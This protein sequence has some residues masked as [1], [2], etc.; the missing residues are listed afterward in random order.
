MPI[1][2]SIVNEDKSI[3]FADDNE[4][5]IGLCFSGG[6]LRAIAFQLG[7]LRAL[8]KYAL[9][10]SVKVISAVSGGAI[11]AAMYAYSEGSFEAFEKDVVLLLRQG[12]AG[13]LLRRI[14]FSFR[15]VLSFMTWLIS[16]TSAFL[17]DSI[18]ALLTFVTLHLRT[19]DYNHTPGFLF[20]IR[21]PFRRWS[22][23]TSVLED[24]LKDKIFKDKKLGSARRNNVE[25]VLN[26]TDLINTG[27][28][29][30]TSRRSGCK[31]FGDIEDN[32]VTVAHAVAASS[33]HPVFFPAIDAVYTFIDK[34]G[35]SARKNVLLSD[36]GIIDN[37][38]TTC[39]R[40]DR[41]PGDDYI[42]FKTDYIVISTAIQG[43][44]DSIPY[45]LIPR[46][47]RVSETINRRLLEF[48]HDNLKKSLDSRQIEGFVFL[49]LSNG[50]H[51]KIQNYP[52]N[53]FAMKQSDIELIMDR[54]EKMTI[55]YLNK[56]CITLLK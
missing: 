29:Y 49:C 46:I 5:G 17:A 1:Q 36:G 56:N 7:C 47:I 26:A 33:A 32:N 23:R 9:L 28:F 43:K 18:R 41:L 12:L 45:W 24:I 22:S 54:G 16:G 6:G 11:L 15:T 44:K 3:S 52:T 35:N 31:T 30:F 51:E 10:D 20:R 38:G 27:H 34:A 19:T 37:L 53:F 25:I 14:F 55:E 21:P 8:K 48:E 39:L 42:T 4:K 13:S 50:S 2:T 40:P